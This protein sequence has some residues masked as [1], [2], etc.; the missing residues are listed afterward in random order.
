MR[1]GSALRLPT[2]LF[3]A[4]LIAA[5]CMVGLL[6]QINTGSIA[7]T[8]TDQGGGVIPGATVEITNSDLGVS[9]T[10]ITNDA[11]AFVAQALRPGIYEVKAEMTGF[12]SAIRSNVVVRVQD[13]VD[14]DISLEVGEM[15]ETVV[16]RETVAKLQTET[17][18][19]GTVIEEREI[20]DLP[21]D[22]RNYSDLILLS[23]GAVPAPGTRSNPREARLNVDGNFSLQNFFALNGVDNNTFT[24]NAQER[25]PQVVQPPPDALQH[26]KVQTR[27]YDA[28][29]GFAQGAVINAELKSGANDFHG[30]GFWFHRNDNL[31]ANNFFAN[32]SGIGKAEELRNQLGGVL[33][34]PIVPD[35]TF[36]FVDY[37]R[38]ESRKGTTTSGTVPTAAMK[39][40]IFTGVRDL[41][42]DR[43]ENGDPYYPAI[44]PCI[45]EVNDI[46][47][48][49]ATRTDGLPCADP[50]GILLAQLYPDPN[51]GTFGFF[52]A[53]DIPLEQDS[54]DVR[55]DH[56]INENNLFYGTYSF[57][58]TDTIVEQGPFPNP[59]ATGG[60]TGQSFVRGQLAALTWNNIVNPQVVNSLRFGF[61]R[62]FS[63]TGSVA[64]EGD[65]GPE[66]GLNNLPGAFAFGLPPIRV[67]GFSFLGT[68]EWRPQFQ[69]SQVYQVL[70]NLSWVRGNHSMKFG[71][72]FKR[73][74]N[75]FL[76]IKAPNGRY[77]IPNNWTNDGFANLLLGNL[78]RIEQTTA[79]VPHNYSDG[80]MFYAQDSWKA[81][82]DLTVNYG[83]RYEYF[84]PFIERDD[85]TS[86]FDPTANGGRGALITANPA[87][88]PGNN[89]CTFDCLQRTSESGVFGRALV[90]PDRNNFAPRIGASLRVKDNMVLRGGYA[91]F[92]QALDRMGSS[93]VIQLNPPQLID[94]RGFESEFNI[95]PFLLLRDDFPALTT[96][97][98]PLS[99]DL[100]GRDVNETA[101]YSQQYSFGTQFQMGQDYLLDVAYVGQT[102]DDIRKLRPLNQGILVQPGVDNIVQPFPDWARL[103]DFLASDGNANYNSLQVQLR[104]GF[105]NGL[106]FN[107]A[108]TWGKALG[109]TQDNLSGGASAN[110]VRPQNAQ[111]LAADYGRL[112]FDQNQRLVLNWVWELPFGPGKDYLNDGPMANILGGWQ[113]N[114]IFSSTSGAPIGI[115]ASDRSGTRSQNARANCI[116][117]PSGPETVDQFFNTAAFSQPDNFTFG[118][119]GV[120][121]LSGWS[122]TLFDLSVFKNFALPLTEESKL[123]F[124][125]E[126]F[127][128]FN[129]P[130]FNNPQ[131]SFT[132]G[133]FGETSQVFD[134]SK[135]GRVIQFGLKFIF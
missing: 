45:D 90:R 17:A 113:F 36:F 1:G 92:Y 56:N 83:L 129:T 20:V 117:N 52:S 128:A 29:F 121:S 127:N 55:I 11:G 62:I 25:S 12:K 5:T 51:N 99:I 105:S 14:L 46:V 93:A 32:R 27:T 98:D 73:A 8:V 33:G 63:N 16:V 97:F 68:S 64:P 50:A 134:A 49:S 91:I 24:T 132:S 116:G 119:C 102:T 84:T 37:Q 71:F 82:P 53:P 110:N 13:R 21:L 19:Q 4:G 39:N 59:L 104:K 66:F 96:E 57:L 22:G 23:P 122:H 47:N 72:E 34:G 43:D 120:A 9:L 101:P 74:I 28:E 18:Q 61:N 133:R 35:R 10:L 30:T 126:F 107:L 2:T 70:D 15:T 87:P 88:L 44:V 125:A 75:N 124:R 85:L 115:S 100:R 26:F 131:R 40:G 135:E 81:T 3:W 67:S 58:E 109:D 79:L 54:F 42:I 114:G 48:L 65:A 103:S 130:Q 38:T 69:V 94:F 86:N 111:D 80:Y 112:V 106:A 6:G 108:Y 123:Q 31:N 7:G 60:F 76:D 89:P 95:P 77:I 78:D 118:N 41:I